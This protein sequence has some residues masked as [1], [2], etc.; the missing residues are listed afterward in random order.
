ML[1]ETLCAWQ[2]LGQKPGGAVGGHQF[3]SLQS[4]VLLAMPQHG[5]AYLKNLMDSF[6][7]TMKIVVNQTFALKTFFPKKTN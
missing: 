2:A 4:S 7:E 3:V 5:R 6:A 1:L